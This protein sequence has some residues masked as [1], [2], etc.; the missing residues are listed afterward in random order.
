MASPA[1]PARTVVKKLAARHGLCRMKRRPLSHLRCR[2][3]VGTGQASLAR[4][5]EGGPKGG[6]G[7]AVDWMFRVPHR[8]H[9][10]RECTTLSDRQGHLV[11]LLP[12]QHTVLGNLISRRRLFPVASPRPDVSCR[13]SWSYL[14]SL[15]SRTLV[16]SRIGRLVRGEDN[17][18]WSCCGLHQRPVSGSCSE[19]VDEGRTACLSSPFLLH[20]HSLQP[21]RVSLMGS[22]RRCCAD[23]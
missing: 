18:G 11:I 6:D 22:S 15:P 7:V 20:L 9:Q 3:E 8:G 17:C 2:A 4:C 10:Q 5:D 23:R 16:R 13:A 14:A 12:L 19:A 21:A 1:S